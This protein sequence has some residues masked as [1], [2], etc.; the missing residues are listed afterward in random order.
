MQDKM[1]TDHCYKQFENAPFGCAM[2][3]LR[4]NNSKK[5][6][7]LCFLMVN[8]AFETI[9]GLK[10]S[11]ILNHSVQE[12]LQPILDNQINWD[13][14]YLN[15]ANNNQTKETETYSELLQR[16]LKIQCYLYE[17]NIYT[18]IITDI[19][20]EKKKCEEL[21]AF[22]T[23]NFDLLCIADIKGNFIKANTTWSEILGYSPQE[24]SRKKFLDFIHPDDFLSTTDAIV[25]MTMQGD[26]T[27]S[28][29]RF[30]CKDGT[31]HHIEWRSCFRSNQIYISARDITAINLASEKLKNHNDRLKS[32]VKILEYNTNNIQALLDFALGEL[33]KTIDSKYGFISYYSEETQEF[34]MN[35]WSKDAMK[36][37]AIVEPQTVYSLDKTGIWGEAVR[38]R[39]PIL[40]NNLEEEHPLKKGYPE[41]H[42][43]L[44]RFLAI[45]VFFQD[46]IVAVAGVANKEQEYDQ[47]DIVQMTL[48]MNDVWKTAERI[49]SEQV[50]HTSSELWRSIID[51][52]PSGITTTTLEGIITSTSPTACTMWG[53]DSDK[54]IIGRNILEF[55]DESHLQRSISQ[56]EKLLKGEKIALTEYLMIHKDGTKFY[57]EA[58]GELLHDRQGNPTGLL[59]VERDITERK[60]TEEA[61]Q[62]S[63]EK[64]RLLVENTHDI[65]YTLNTEGIFTFVSQAWAKLLGHEVKD[66]IDKPFPPFVHPDDIGT[67]FAFLQKVIETKQLQEGVEYRV[68]HT[69]GTWRWHT[70]SGAPL[71]DDTD[72]IIGFYGIARDITERKQAE[73]ALRLSEEKYRLLVESIQDIILTINLEGVF[74]YVSPAWKLLLGHPAEQVVG[75][76]FLQYIHPDDIAGCIY[77]LQKAFEEQDRICDIEYRIKHMDGSWRWHSASSSPLKD[78]KG[79]LIGLYGIVRDITKR[80]QTEEA[81]RLSEE[82]YRLL[83]ENSHDIIYTVDL[84]G[85]FTFVSPAWTVLLG[86]PT[87]EV[88]GKSFSRFVHPD[89]IQLIINYLQTIIETKERANDVEY[90]IQ[91]SDGTWRWH[92]TTSCPMNDESGIIIGIYGIARD[93]T[94]RKLFEK[95]LKENEELYSSILKASP[96]NITITNMNGK[97][98][99]VSPAGVKMTG[100]NNEKDLLG[101]FITDFLLPED[102]S[103]AIENFKLITQGLS[104]GTREYR[105]ILPNKNIVYFEENGELIRNAEGRPFGIVFILRDITKR[106]NTEAELKQKSEQ[107]QLLNTEKDKLFSIIAHDLRSPFNSLLGLTD[108]MVSDMDKFEKEDLLKFLVGIK[109]SVRNIYSLLENLLDWSRIQRNMVGFYPQLFLLAPTIEQN[110]Q[111]HIESANKKGI[112]IK[113]EIPEKL[114]VYADQNMFGSTIRNLISNAIK[115][116]CNGGKVIVSAIP[117]VDNFVQISVSDTG[118]G[119]EQNLIKKLFLLNKNTN[120]RGTEGESCTGL[121]L[122]ICKDFIERQGGKIWIESN[123]GKGSTFYFTIPGDV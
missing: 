21:D 73:E 71:K 116:T 79:N 77:H 40:I 121:G 117:T 47:S 75:T 4:N 88:T 67:C 68:L 122:V 105:A 57:A 108:I 18:A 76:L 89:D 63:E 106:K 87:D 30:L 58:D 32:L 12:V 93:T 97:I 103:R 62:K 110:L 49:K 123:V 46:K 52:S 69:N 35:S 109:K 7:T 90:R 51:A 104:L 19:T 56:M 78:E 113:A 5:P 29:T 99:M 3:H 53:Y 2:L 14:F 37:C 9:T 118:I 17:E 55:I 94:E 86:H 81:L 96:D 42:V 91:H 48:L 41:G 31:Y 92:T 98:L 59:F 20:R 25:K 23:I 22:F 74:T 10:S 66:V 82:K 27:G 72:T 8:P 36:E 83:V 60:Q 114:M 33:V 1:N 102:K 119:M 100:H 111:L 13:E 26:S 50:H 80:K 61:L 107:L 65:I 85:I 28:V 54:E 24:L 43:Q 11:A 70:T 120:H 101:H 84:K 115:F 39:K 6:A 45:P 16:W 15:L 38:Q 112:L 64:Y 95:A 44:K 34:T